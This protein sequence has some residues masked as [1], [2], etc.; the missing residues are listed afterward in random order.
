MKDTL[1]RF[2]RSLVAAALVTAFII[3]Q[4]AVAQASQHVVSPSDL[5]QATVDASQ[6]RQQ[7]IDTLNKFL[8]SEQ[9]KAALESAHMNP[10]QVKQAVAGLSDEEL[11]RLSARAN[12]AQADFAAGYIGERDLILILIAIAVLILIIVVLR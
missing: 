3:P 5:Q 10:E 6:A 2:V 8:S 4:N 11:A 1:W 12:K 9:A 7:N